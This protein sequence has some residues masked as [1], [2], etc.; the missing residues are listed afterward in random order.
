MTAKLGGASA[1]Y[2]ETLRRGQQHLARARWAV[3]AVVAV[4]TAHLE[5]ITLPYLRTAPAMEAAM[6]VAYPLLLATLAAW[7]ILRRE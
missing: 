2:D 4:I 7:A 1:P 6:I 5:L 3:V